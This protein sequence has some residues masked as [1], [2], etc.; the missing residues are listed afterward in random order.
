MAKSHGCFSQKDQ[1]DVTREKVTA[2]GRPKDVFLKQWP[3]H[4]EKQWCPSG[5]KLLPSQTIPAIDFHL[6]F[7]LSSLDNLI[8]QLVLMSTLKIRN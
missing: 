6:Y 7:L 1:R 5:A 3:H 4:H 8:Q 2:E